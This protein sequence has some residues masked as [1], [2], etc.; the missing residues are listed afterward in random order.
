MAFIYVTEDYIPL[1]TLQYL[2]DFRGVKKKLFG[3]VHAMNFLIETK[4]NS[5]L[6]PDILG[7]L[8]MVPIK[9]LRDEVVNKILMPFNYRTLE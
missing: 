6:S 8:G 7:F 5:Y 3:N 1:E 9:K 4:G 2:G